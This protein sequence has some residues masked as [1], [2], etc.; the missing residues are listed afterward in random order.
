MGIRDKDS[1]MGGGLHT[2]DSP[3]T[4]KPYFFFNCFTYLSNKESQ[5]SCVESALVEMAVEGPGCRGATTKLD[6]SHR[7]CN[8][9]CKVWQSVAI[10]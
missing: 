8:F 1:E 9:Q 7:I 6:N 10:I 5:V 4:N 2:H 3:E